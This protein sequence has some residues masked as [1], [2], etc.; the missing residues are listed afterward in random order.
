MKELEDQVAVCARCGLC[1]TLCPMFAQTGREADLARG[2]LALLDG[3]MQELLK[4]PRAVQDRLTRCLLCGACAANCPSGVKALDIFI[5]ARAILAGYL[6]LS[7]LK[8]AVFRKM[9]AHPDVFNRIFFWGAKFQGIFIKPVDDLLGSSCSRFL[10]PLLQKRHF[11]PL[12][13]VAFIRQAGLIDTPAGASGLKAALFIGC[14]VDKVFTSVGEAAVEVLE[15]RGVGVVLPEAQGCCGI[16]ALSSGDAAAFDRLVGH[17]IKVFGSLEFDYLVTPCATCAATI[18]KLWPFMSQEYPVAAQAQI[19][20]LAEKTLDTNQ[21]LVEKVGLE[22]LPKRAEEKI[23]VTY[24]DPCHLKKSLG[25]AAQP[26]A[27]IQANPRYDLREMPEAD[28]C[29]GAGGT[30]TLQHYEISAAIGRRKLENIR[31][32]GAAVVAT[33]CPGCMMQLVDMISQAGAGV[34]VRHALEIYAETLKAS[35]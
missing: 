35:R 13:P 8:K 14:L 23:P 5:K 12:A 30:F 19:A 32:S 31:K 9:L 27:L 16:P 10:S 11:K 21:F 20:R 34:Q 17:N 7:P 25:V 18:K 22:Q 2:K 4:D 15:R 26:R 1:Q 24:H 28:W 6:G 29:C 3:L 33:G